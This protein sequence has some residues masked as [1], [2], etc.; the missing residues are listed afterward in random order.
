MKK[1]SFLVLAI[2]MSTISYSQTGWYVQSVPFSGSGYNAV[3]FL[4]DNTGWAAGNNIVIKTTN[5]GLN[6]T[7]LT[8]NFSISVTD[9]QFLNE[10]TGWAVGSSALIRKTTNGGV[11]WFIGYCPE[12]SNADDFLQVQF[13]NENTGYAFG[14]QRICK[15]TNSGLN[16]TPLTNNLI[17]YRGFFFDVNTGW[18]VGLGASAKTTNGG[19]NWSQNQFTNNWTSSVHFRDYNTGW[20]TSRAGEIF[21]STN[22]GNNWNLQYRDSN[23]VFTGLTFT[24][25]D[26][27]WAIGEK[28]NPANR[29]FIM[30][31]INAG[32]TW[33]EQQ[34]PD[35]YFLDIFMRNSL[36]GWIAGSSVLH[37][38]DGGS[39]GINQIST[40]VPSAYSLNQNYPNPFNPSTNVKFSIVKAGDVKVI[41]YDI[42][43]RE[44]QTL[45]NESLKPGTYEAAFD[46]SA[47]NSGVYFYKL[48]TNGFTETKRM[49]LIK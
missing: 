42:M 12:C 23:R 10:L 49:I 37:T 28:I 25:N 14:D 13:L 29:C 18:I 45:V 20:I 38:S 35:T 47:L 15:T 26:T 21:K 44:V 34:I 4:N 27:G 6:W 24:S 41:V 1:L 33:S 3:F 22:G 30:K 16:W 5:Q 39:V 43:G 32:Q 17:V 48:I 36:D 46:G 19:V 7:L 40:Q 31:T 8:N 2:L 11:N 9:I